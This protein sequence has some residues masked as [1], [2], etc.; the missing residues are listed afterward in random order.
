M[1]RNILDALAD[2]DRAYRLEDWS[3]ERD[4][5]REA[6]EELES[7]IAVYDADDPDDRYVDYRPPKGLERKES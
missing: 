5:L 6:A 1:Y 3:I 4:C 2:Y 7:L